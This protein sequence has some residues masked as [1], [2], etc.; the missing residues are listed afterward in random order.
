VTHFVVIR[1]LRVLTVNERYGDVTPLSGQTCNILHLDPWF[2]PEDN[3]WRKLRRKPKEP[4][5]ETD[6]GGGTYCSAGCGTIFRMTPEGALA[7]LYIFCAHGV[8]FNGTEAT[9]IAN[10]GSAIETT[11]PAGATSGFITVTGDGS[12]LKSNKPFNVTP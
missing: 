11:V 2:Y 6:G 8:S 5:G 3:H 10:S 12:T 4:D 7:T 1:P 9:I